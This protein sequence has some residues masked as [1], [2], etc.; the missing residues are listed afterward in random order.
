MDELLV[1][2]KRK[3]AVSKLTSENRYERNFDKI[4]DNFEYAK[5]YG[6]F[7]QALNLYSIDSGIHEY[8]LC[9]SAKSLNSIIDNS[10]KPNSIQK[11]LMKVC[12]G[13][14]YETLLENI[15]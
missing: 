13:F 3:F 11:F 8:S 6:Q 14:E 7:P 2:T 5:T 4:F 9:S 12:F 1:K 10:F 15:K